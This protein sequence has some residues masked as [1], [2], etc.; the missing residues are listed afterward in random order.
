MLGA[1]LEAGAVL[2]KQMRAIKNPLISKWAK[3]RKPLPNDSFRKIQDLNLSSVYMK[4][5]GG[6]FFM[7][8][9]L[10]FAFPL[11]LFFVL[12]IYLFRCFSRIFFEL[13]SFSGSSFS[14]FHFFNSPSPPLRRPYPSSSSTARVTTSPASTS[15]TT[16]SPPFL[17]SSSATN[18]LDISPH[19]KIGLRV[20][21]PFFA[22]WRLRWS[23]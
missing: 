17:R 16:L 19:R 12:F 15:L 7:L 8:P 13:P 4:V 2:T 11:L 23:I 14:A 9:L 5:R 22:S 1:L 10:L 6:F 21:H 20:F 3:V 18:L